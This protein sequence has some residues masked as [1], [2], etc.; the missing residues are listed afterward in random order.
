[1][2]SSGCIRSADWCFSMFVAI[3]AKEFGKD[4][5]NGQTSMQWHNREKDWYNAERRFI[6]AAPS[7]K[8]QTKWIQMIGKTKAIVATGR[9]GSA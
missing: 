4:D 1:M 2:V 5:E 3:T 8:A 6:F 7:R 9:P